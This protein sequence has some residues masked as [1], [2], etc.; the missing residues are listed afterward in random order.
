M[1]GEGRGEE[2][3][4]GERGGEGIGRRRGRGGSEGTA[5]GCRSNHVIKVHCLSIQLF[6]W[7]L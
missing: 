7:C 3:I 1:E 2:S 4:E 6:R 5:G